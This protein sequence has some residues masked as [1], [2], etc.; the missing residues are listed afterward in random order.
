MLRRL[1]ISLRF[2]DDD[3]EFYEGFIEE[4]KNNRE[5]STL[6]LDLLRVYYENEVVR[7]IVENYRIENSPFLK[8]HAEIN[9]IAMEHSKNTIATNMMGDYTRN[10]V[11]K[12]D[13]SANNNNSQ[14]ESP[15]LIAASEEE[16][17]SRINEGVEKALASILSGN[18]SHILSEIQNKIGNVNLQQ[19]VR[20]IV[21][22][23]NKT[24]DD[25]KQN[26]EKQIPNV[27]EAPKVEVPIVEEDKTEE[28][29]KTVVEEVVENKPKKPSSFSKLM[30]SL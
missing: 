4:K 10:E 11:K 7:E 12:T 14:Q 28:A 19:D 20:P 24:I 25:S 17:Q 23:T 5:L 15:K 21:E 3:S 27:V 26:D 29:L 16:M 2:D 13:N 8:I 30:G 18:G 9:R 22:E 6:I 1:P